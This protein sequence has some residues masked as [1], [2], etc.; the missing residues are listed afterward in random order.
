MPVGNRISLFAYFF[1]IFVRLLY[2]SHDIT[3]TRPSLA[4]LAAFQPAL[5][6]PPLPLLLLPSP[7]LLLLPPPPLLLLPLL[8]L[9]P[10]SVVVI[11]SCQSSLLVVVVGCQSSLLWLSAGHDCNRCA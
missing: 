2:F 10:P 8:L 11:V 3:E 5:A 9:L 6:Q 1:L 4:A 7:P